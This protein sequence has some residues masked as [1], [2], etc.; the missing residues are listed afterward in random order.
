MSP[1]KFGHITAAITSTTSNWPFGSFNIYFILYSQGHTLH[2][3][4]ERWN[5]HSVYLMAE[6][7]DAHWINS[8]LLPHIFLSSGH[9]LHWILQHKLPH[10]LSCATLITFPQKFI[11]INLSLQHLP[12]ALGG[13]SFAAKN[14]GKKIIIITI[15]T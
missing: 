15:R 8:T 13:I 3:P 12:E 9:S 14:Q 2:F 5:A 10:G 11:D 6:C 7:T 4:Q 1:E